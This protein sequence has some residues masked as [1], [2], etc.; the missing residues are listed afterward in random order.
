VDHDETPDPPIGI[1][2]A[3]A[4]GILL[5]MLGLLAV[6]LI[7]FYL[8]KPPAAPL[9][10]E[11]ASDP[12][13]ARGQEIYVERCIACHGP[14]GRGDGPL[15]RNLPGP[16]PR[17]L[18]DEPWKH[19]DKPEQVL[20]VL[21]NGVKDAQMPAWAGIFGPDDLKSVAAYV[22]QIAGRPVPGALRAK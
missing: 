20:A 4:R 9:P 21:E 1:D 10:P 12:V 15:A 18:V 6:G 5:G 14:R 16:P 13:L 17:N 11:I 19:G 7:A 22:Y 8:L 3:V 2:P